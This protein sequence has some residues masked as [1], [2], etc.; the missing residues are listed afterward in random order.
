MSLRPYPNPSKQTV[1]RIEK[2][3]YEFISE[4]KP[5]KIKRDVLTKKKKKK[6][7]LLT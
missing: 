7:K 5:E 2:L 6:K 4:G 3:M 1:K